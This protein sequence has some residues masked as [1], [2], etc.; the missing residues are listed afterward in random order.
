MKIREDYVFCG[1]RRRW[2]IFGDALRMIKFEH[3]L[4]AL[5]FALAS[6]LVATE[7]RPTVKITFLIIAAMV[8]ARN[9]AMSFNRIVDRHIDAKN[10]RTAERELPTKKV[11]LTFAWIFCFVNMALFVLVS[12]TFN[13]LTLVLSPVAL[14]IIFGYSY[15]KHI[16][17]YSHIFLGLA[18][19]VA[20]V[21]T[22]I[23]ATGTVSL[24]SLILGLAVLFWVAGFDIIYATQDY[25]FD[26]EAGLKSLVVKLGIGP[27]LLCSRLVHLVACV[28]LVLAGFTQG[29][30][31][32]YFLGC[33]AVAIMLFYEQ[34]L[35]KKDDLSRVNTAFFTL[36]GYMSVLYFV[37]VFLDTM[38]FLKN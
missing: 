17:H 3:S 35:V 29:L 16:S 15:T 11:S 25:H 33:F 21:A 9:A 1:Q 31:W 37:F 10:P 26:K 36:N 32:P 12:A 38:F 4:F 7:G 19:G 14:I 34:I 23:A 27:S 2:A 28:L 18:L 13:R 6:L 20:P 8:T 24:F 22:W 5:P 30:H